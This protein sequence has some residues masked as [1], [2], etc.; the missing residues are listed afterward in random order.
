MPIGV[1]LDPEHLTAPAGADIDGTVVLTNPSAEPVHVRVVIA[2]EVAGWA[3]VEPGDV[4]V[5]PGE[6]RALDLRFRLPRGAPG[7]VGAIPFTIRV[8]SDQEGEGGATAVGQPRRDRRGGAGVAADAR[9]VQ[10]DAVRDD[11]GCRRQ[12]RRHAGAGPAD[13][14]R[15]RRRVVDADPDS[16]IVE[17][18]STAFAKVHVRPHKR[19]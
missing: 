13:P 14:R 9:H 5:Q 18:N 6:E 16:L 15:R 19:R 10:G 12:P 1:R 8:L 17:P 3:S 2:S 4:W 11:A 7:G